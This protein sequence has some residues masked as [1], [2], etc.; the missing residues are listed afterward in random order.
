MAKVLTDAAIRKYRATGE[1][2]IIR[3]ALARSLYLIISESGTKSFGMR[4]RRPDG[5]A[6]KLVLGP[7]DVSGQE[8]TED[9]VVGMPLSLAAARML[10]AKI[11]RERALGRDPIG[12]HKA[13]KHRR[14]SEIA[15]QAANS[16]GALVRKHIE[17]HCKPKLRRWDSTARLLGLDRNLNPIAGG[18]AERWADR[19]IRQIDSHDI[20]NLITE[21][22]EVGVP[23]IP[24][25]RQATSESRALALYAAISSLF[26]WC[27]KH[28]RIDANPVKG[29][30]KPA[31]SRARDR[32]LTT[33]EIRSFW[34]AADTISGL[35][36]AAVKLLLLTGSRVSE[37]A[38]ME[39]AELA[40]D[41]SQLNLP[42]TRTKNKKPHVVP[43]A[44]IAREIIAGVPRI[45]GSAFVFTNT[46]KSPIQNWAKIKRRLDA[47]MAIGPWRLHD[48]RRT[49]VTGMAELGIRPDV[50]ELAVNHAS[51]RSSVA[52]V[53]NKSELL[54]ERRAALER[55][56]AHVAGLVSGEPTNIVA[57]RAPR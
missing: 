34:A 10:A 51:G 36:G 7:Y 49:C 5:K 53:Y 3:D 21:A 23:G 42:A 12:E 31:A 57:L 15:E 44:P 41:L 39:W 2:R 43:L 55:W 20:Y 25:T 14:R 13:R 56:A 6:G 17:E 52:G 16:F 47:A 33:D 35:A 28:R 22:R 46:G 26:G 38:E 29:V 8:L 27:I 37:I 18:L 50:I 9:P 40:D 30:F 24:A 48:L 45:A 54:P 32:V 1:K 4:F 19:D 11:H